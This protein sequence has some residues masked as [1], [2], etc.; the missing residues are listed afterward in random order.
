LTLPLSLTSFSP[1][2][3]QKLRHGF[4]RA[5][6]F[7][8]LRHG[9]RRASRFQIP[10]GF[11]LPDPSRLPSGVPHASRCLTAS[12]R[13]DSRFQIPHGFLPAYLT[14]P[15]APSWLPACLTLPDPSRL[16]LAKHIRSL[17]CFSPL[18]NPAPLLPIPPKVLAKKFGAAVVSL[19][20]R[21]YGKSS[22]FK[23]LSTEN[24]KYLSSKQA[25][26]NGS[27]QLCMWNRM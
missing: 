17:R 19:E 23:S 13:H 20:H 11:L 14:L 12:F 10:H 25:L 7:Q 6:R 2:R 24:L 15:E 5:S 4:R 3:F 9:F 27:L 26:F 22:P 8:K 21:Y 1:S 18:C 16:N